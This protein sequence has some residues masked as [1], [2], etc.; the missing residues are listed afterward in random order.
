MCDRPFGKIWVR[1]DRPF[2]RIW[3]L[4]DRMFVVGWG[5]VYLDF[6][7]DL[8]MVGKTRPYRIIRMF[9]CFGKILVLDDRMFVLGW[10]RVY[11]DCWWE[12]GMVG[13]TRP[14]RII[15]MFDCFG[16]ILVLGD[17][18]FVLGW[19]RVYLYCQRSRL[20]VFR[21]QHL[22]YQLHHKFSRHQSRHICNDLIGN[23][24]C[25]NI[26]LIFV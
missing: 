9:D 6:W 11:L 22:F 26:R 8:G 20:F 24:P 18:I 5:R 1:G 3:V 21:P 2:G 16:K 17:R 15:R 14:Y 12:L 7:C 4:G 19:R 10:G 23:S 13:K 25:H